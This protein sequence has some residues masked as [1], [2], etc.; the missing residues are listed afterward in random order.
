MSLH[1]IVEEIIIDAQ[2]YE[3][4]RAKVERLRNGN[5]RYVLNME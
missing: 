3:E 4:Y 5:Q 2:K 1:A